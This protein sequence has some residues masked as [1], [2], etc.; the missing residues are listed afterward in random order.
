MLRA[1]LKDCSIDFCSVEGWDDTPP[2]VETG[3]AAPFVLVG[4]GATVAAMVGF[5][6]DVFV[7]NGVCVAVGGN[8]VAV[9][10]GV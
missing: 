7:G 2:P 8:G 6:V 10:S 1:A 5:G 4:L 3:A 9:G